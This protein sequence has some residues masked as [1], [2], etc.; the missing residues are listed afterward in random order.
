MTDRT[1]FVHQRRIFA[2]TLPRLGDAVSLWMHP[3][4]R[5]EEFDRILDAA[6]IRR[7]VRWGD[8]S[9]IDADLASAMRANPESW[10]AYREVRDAQLVAATDGHTLLARCPGC[11]VWDAELNPLALA[12]ALRAPYWPVVDER[13]RLAVP[14]LA[15]AR[16][17][18][19]LRG[20]EPAARL[21]VRLPGGT[22]R[23]VRFVDDAD[24]ALEAWLRASEELFRTPDRTR[25]WEA[26]S[27]GW[28]AILHLASLAAGLTGHNTPG[29]A[30]LVRLADLPLAEFL[31]L[32]QMYA[33]TH[34]VAVPED[35]AVELDCPRC[36]AVFGALAASVRWPDP[37]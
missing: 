31:A 1:E 23:V 27:P 6:E 8:G 14:A 32:D 21:T 28:T 35:N 15:L 34:I 2:V 26:D 11:R 25:D 17:E 29:P 18:R 22:D 24:R 37:W 33:L 36:G 7:F 3:A 20:I 19:D 10:Q 5:T 16:V 4:L 9:P 30:D 13:D 12:V